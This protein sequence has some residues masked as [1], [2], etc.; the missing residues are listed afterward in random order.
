MS[1][2]RTYLPCSSRHGGFHS[3]LAGKEFMSPTRLFC[4]MSISMFLLFAACSKENKSAAQGAEALPSDF[5]FA[6]GQGGGFTG[7][8]Q[9]YTIDS[10]GAIYAWQGKMP[11]ENLK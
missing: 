2:M 6:F 3:S 7:M 9:G 11:G 1:I 5:R 8:W 4:S 10:S